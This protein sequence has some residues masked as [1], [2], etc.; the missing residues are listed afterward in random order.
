MTVDPFTLSVLAVKSLVVLLVLLF[1][2]RLMGKRQIGQWNI[3]DLAMVMAVANAVQNAMTRG[4]GEV[5]VG[6][7]TA[8]TILVGAWTLT[9]LFWRAPAM[10]EHILGTPTVLVLDGVV[11]RDRMRQERITDDELATA[12]RQHGLTRP[13]QAHMAILEIDGSI[14]VVPKDQAV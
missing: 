12:L 3:Y 5:V 4:R 8:G 1:A 10:E 9:R 2:L 6:F 7:V 13:E 11:L 14:S